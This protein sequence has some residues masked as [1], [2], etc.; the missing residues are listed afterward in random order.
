MAASKLS[1]RQTVC[2]GNIVSN[3]EKGIAPFK[4]VVAT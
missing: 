1:G 2:G 4:L 3:Q